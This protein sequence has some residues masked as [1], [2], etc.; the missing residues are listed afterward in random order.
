MSHRW[1]GISLLILGTTI[2]SCS[3]QDKLPKGREM[4]SRAAPDSASRAFVW[5]P[6]LSGALGATVS[7]PYQVWIQSLQGGRDTR[8]VL[9]ADK[10]H[11]FHLGWTAPTQLEIC[12]ADAQILQF[13]NFFIVATEDSPTIYS[14][15]IV[16]K[17][18]SRLDECPY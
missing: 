3:H 15:E 11:G 5:L 10:T 9:V 13:Q 8:L 6:E 2:G 14:V 1:A 18:V 12:Y 17:K 4:L 7:Q 16:L